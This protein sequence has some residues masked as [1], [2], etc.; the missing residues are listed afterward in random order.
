MI[1]YKK[2]TEKI[3]LV[4]RPGLRANQW[5]LLSSLVKRPDLAAI[6]LHHPTA[7]VSLSWCP[8]KGDRTIMAVGQKDGGVA[9]WSLDSSGSNEK[10]Q[11][12]GLLWGHPGK[13]VLKL[14]YHP[15]NGK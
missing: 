9:V 11:H 4:A 3:D 15:G 7:V 5:L 2:E 8:S 12:V 6:Q 13:S 1:F 14:S 10:P